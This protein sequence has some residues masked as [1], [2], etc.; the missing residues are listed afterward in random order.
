MTEP[1]DWA[2]L[3]LDLRVRSLRGTC[4]DAAAYLRERIE[5]AFCLPT[6]P[7]HREGGGA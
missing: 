2:G 7:A 1:F 3:E 4:A 5:A 6:A